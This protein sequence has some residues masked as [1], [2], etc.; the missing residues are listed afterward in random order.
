[1]WEK[2]LY[3]LAPVLQAL[4]T[5]V[6]AMSPMDEKEDDQGPKHA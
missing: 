6:L 5:L 4:L 1:M 2:V 3:L